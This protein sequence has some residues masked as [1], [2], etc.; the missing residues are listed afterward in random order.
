M[1]VK[2]L[3]SLDVPNGCK[4]KRKMIRTQAIATRVWVSIFG[5][6]IWSPSPSSQ[7]MCLVMSN[8]LCI[9]YLEQQQGWIVQESKRRLYETH[10]R[11]DTVLAILRSSGG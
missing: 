6:A 5:A 11:K 4:A 9:T 2:K 8:V 7:R 3:L 1:G 10:Q